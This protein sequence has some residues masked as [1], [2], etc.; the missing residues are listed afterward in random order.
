MKVSIITPAYNCKET[1]KETFDSVISQTFSDWEWIIIEDQSTD[2]SYEFIKELVK[3]DK[4]IILLQTDKN[5]G[6]AKARNLG[7]EKA[8]G[9]Y[10]AFLDADDLWSKDKLEHQIK[11]MEDNDYAF[12]Y[13][14]Y[15]VLYEDNK[16]IAFDPKRLS[17]SYKDLLKACDIGCLTVIYDTQK[18]GKIYM[19]LDAPK[20]EDYAM[21]LDMTRNGLVAHKLNENLATYRVHS[22]SV[23]F[24]K[25]SIIKYHYRVYRKHEG[26]GFFK[27]IYCLIAHSFNKVFYKGY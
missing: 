4:R 20:R 15:D 26:F 27:S 16:R 18:L 6:A 24:N 2:G 8:E 3:D 10:I 14:N 12:T 9:R 13:T 25:F 5:S 11:F 7:I 22:G 1:I 17:S 23:S 19:P 21:W